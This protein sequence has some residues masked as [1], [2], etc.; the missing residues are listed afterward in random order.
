MNESALNPERG[1]PFLP[2]HVGNLRTMGWALPWR[3]VKK[4]LDGDKNCEAH[5]SP[6]CR[7]GQVEPNVDLDELFS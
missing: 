2:I 1:I 3:G 5:A 4:W 6:R 7:M